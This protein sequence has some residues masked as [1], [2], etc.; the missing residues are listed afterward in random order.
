M[1]TILPCYFRYLPEYFCAN[2]ALMDAGIFM[3]FKMS[4]SNVWLAFVKIMLDISYY[5]SLLLKVVIMITF[6]FIDRNGV[7]G[8]R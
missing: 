2:N 4:L 5:V 3:Y 8:I 6:G 7:F 1:N